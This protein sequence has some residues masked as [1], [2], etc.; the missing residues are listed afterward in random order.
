MFEQQ[1]PTS[2]AIHD[3]AP[4][5]T[6][7]A[8]TEHPEVAP[9]PTVEAPAPQAVPADSKPEAVNGGGHW[10]AEAG[11]KGAQRVQQ[12]IEEGK[13]YEQEH[14]LK[15]GRQRIRQL[16][17]LGKRYEQEHDLRPRRSGKRR[18]RLGRGQRK[19]LLATLLRCLIRL[20][21]PSFRADLSRL[22]K[23]LQGEEGRAE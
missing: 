11:R 18:E 12:L 16:I 14:G 10:H 15:R 20:S 4:I 3:A 5:D 13:R 19:E 1:E 23:E 9:A 6:T 2:V 22:V 17:E 8:S 7:T 21:K